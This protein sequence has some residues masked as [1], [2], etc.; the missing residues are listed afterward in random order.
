MNSPRKSVKNQ[1][2]F[3]EAASSKAALSE[4][5][6]HPLTIWPPA[7]GVA[8]GFGLVMLGMASMPLA[9]GLCAVGTGIG[10]T[11]WVVRFFGGKEAFAQKYYAMLHQ[12]FE[13]LKEQ[14]VESLG[15]D[16]KKHGCS[17]GREQVSQFETKFQT[18][19]EVLKRILSEGEIT[20]GRYLS[21]AEAVY[22][23]GIENL[24]R[25]VTIRTS[26]EEIDRVDLEE[27]ISLLNKR[28]TKSSS[29]TRLLRTLL[30]RA[31]IYDDGL[32]EVDELLVTNEEALTTLDKTASAVRRINT[33]GSSDDLTT[34]MADLLSLIGRIT[35]RTGVG[36]LEV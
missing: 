20:Y 9:L 32:K 21:A 3:S 23:S 17:Q 12:Q 22:S 36:A 28:A 34:A 5:V 4:T 30:E 6:Q 26:I 25:I 14:K 33:S 10:V 7:I 24:D 2:D 1:V 35:K 11:N 19:L 8:A 27:R 15:K 13:E 16:L 31:R 29:E 18:L